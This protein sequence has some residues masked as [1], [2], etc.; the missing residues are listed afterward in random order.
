MELH[1]IVIDINDKIVSKTIKKIIENI[2]FVPRLWFLFVLSVV[3]IGKNFRVYIFFDE[4]KKYSKKH[5]NNCTYFYSVIKFVCNIIWIL[6]SSAF[7]APDRAP[8]P[9]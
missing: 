3:I 1:Y 4:N 8:R 9:H 5:G 6:R 2:I 7:C